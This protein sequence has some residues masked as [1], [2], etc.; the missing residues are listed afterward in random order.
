MIDLTLRPSDLR[1]GPQKG[2]CQPE[3]ARHFVRRRSERVS[4]PLALTFPDRD[5]SEE[6]Q[7]EITIG[8]TGR[9]QVV[10]VAHCRRGDRV[11]IISARRATPRER[12]QYEEGITEYRG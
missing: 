12:R 7:R 11:R 9:Q 2:R 6:E 3:Q 4:D 10:F 1:M 5:H 8:H